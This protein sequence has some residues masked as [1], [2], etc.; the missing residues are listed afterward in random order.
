[1]FLLNNNKKNLLKYFMRICS[2]LKLDWV[3]KRVGGEA[4]VLQEGQN[5]TV[6]FFFPHKSVDGLIDDFISRS[7]SRYKAAYVYFTDCK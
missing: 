4:L 6:I 7:S 1:M 3:T 5:T 2:I